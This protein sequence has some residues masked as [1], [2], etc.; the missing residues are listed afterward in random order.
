MSKSLAELRA[1]KPQSRPERSLTV[2]L[3][4][5]LVAEV[6]ALTE[7]LSSLPVDAVLEDGERQGPPRRVGEGENPRIGEIRSRLTELLDEMA[8]HE[9]ELRLRAVSDGEWRRWVNEHPARA[10]GSKGFQRDQEVAAGYC[11][12]D[13]LLDELGMFV[14]SWNDEPLTDGDW[15]ILSANLGSPDLKQAATSVVSMH[16]SRLD[17]RQWRSGL[18]ANLKRLHASASPAISPSPLDGSTDGSPG[19][20]NTGSTETETPAR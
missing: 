15:E 5:D 20:S 11:N 6:Q 14:A 16:E 7:E 4:P 10:E 9:G 13:D 18:S 8:E 19:P 12:A 17:F 3:R 2:C 1:E